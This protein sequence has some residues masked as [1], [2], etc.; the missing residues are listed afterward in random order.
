MTTFPTKILDK[1]DMIRYLLSGDLQTR[2]RE[3]A[4][5]LHPDMGGTDDQFRL[6]MEAKAELEDDLFDLM[7]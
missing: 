6:L 1:E 7:D 4:K 3:L 2:F 5:R